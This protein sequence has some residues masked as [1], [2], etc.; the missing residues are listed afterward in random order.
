MIATTHIINVL[1]A[2]E[3]EFATLHG[4]YMYDG[5]DP[6][7]DGIRIDTSKVGKEVSDLRTRLEDARAFQCPRP[8][9]DLADPVNHPSHYNAGKI[10]VIDFLLDQKMGFL[11]GNVVKYLCRAPHKGNTLQDLKK[12]Q[13]Y[14]NKL[15][16]TLQ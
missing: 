9:I 3:H 11:E 5:V 7:K 1:K 6:R 2:V 15:I 12:A 16:E 13:W 8:L 10:E 4:M 14:L